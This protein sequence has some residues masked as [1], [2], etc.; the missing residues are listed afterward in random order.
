[1]SVFNVLRDI[2]H[3]PFQRESFQPPSVALVLTAEL[4]IAR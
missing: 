2:D 1:M 3:W 4:S